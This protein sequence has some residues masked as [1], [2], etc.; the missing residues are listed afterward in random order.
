MSSVSGV[1]TLTNFAPLIQLWAGFCLLFFYE[2][3]FKHSPLA[4]LVEG[5]KKLHKEFVMEYIDFIT[6]EEIIDVDK[7]AKDNWEEHLLPTIKNLASLTFFY[8]VF[9][10][11]FIGIENVKGL[12]DHYIYALQPINWLIIIYAVVAALFVK[13]KIFHTYWTPIIGIILIVGYFHK[14][15]QINTWLVGHGCWLGEYW[16]YSSISVFTLFTLFSGLAVVLL[17]LLAVW[18]NL[19]SKQR[20]LKK[21]NVNCTLLA[22]V[23]IRSRSINDLPKKL[24]NKIQPKINDKLSEEIETNDVIQSSIREEIVEEYKTLQAGWIQSTS[25]KCRLW[26]S[27]WLNKLASKVK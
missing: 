5:L 21:L 8:S 12:G 23:M 20:S 22:A 7:Y 19:N 3:L 4:N 25:Y 18:R 14:Y 1:I 24:K 13:A 11:V 2:T 16:S 6:K 27:G 9:I 10:L 26:L 15:D 17:R